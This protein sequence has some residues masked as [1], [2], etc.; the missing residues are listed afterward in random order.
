[1]EPNLHF[2]ISERQSFFRRFCQWM[3]L[4][5]PVNLF[6]S[7]KS[8]EKSRQLL[9][10]TEDAPKHYQDNQGIRDAWN[11]SLSTVHPDSSNLIPYL[12]RPAV[13]LLMP[14]TGIKSIILSQA[15]LYG[16]TT[17]FNITNGNASYSHGPVERTLLGAGVFVSSTFFGLI[18]HL[19]QMKYPLNNFW[20]KRTLPIVFLAQVSGMNVFASRSFE[21]HRGI[22]VMDKEGHVVGYSRK[23]GRK[24]IKETAKSRA[25]LF[26]TSALAPELFI[27]IFKR[28][29]FYPQTLLSLK[30]LRMSSTFFMMGLMVPVSFSMFPQVGQIQ[31]SQLEEKIQSSTEEKELFYYRGV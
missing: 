28:T 22:E 19:F 18:P 16:Y 2:W 11:K 31:C 17:A 26:G 23:A 24:A 5:D 6:I 21:H 4:L 9:F 30:I 27:H 14:D 29:R 7:I 20:L 3:D 13:L 1:M 10:T 12:L 8:I 25:V 15:C